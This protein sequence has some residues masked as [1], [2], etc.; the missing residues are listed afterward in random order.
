LNHDYDSD[1]TLKA[2]VNELKKADSL[3]IMSHENEVVQTKHQIWN[4]ILMIQN[5]PMKS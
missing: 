4:V 1:E 3:V 5:L 2:K